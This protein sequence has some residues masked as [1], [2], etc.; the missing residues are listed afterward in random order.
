MKVLERVLGFLNK[1]V[2]CLWNWEKNFCETSRYRGVF[3]ENKFFLFCLEGGL[4][5][6]VEQGLFLVL[7]LFL[8]VVEALFMW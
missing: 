4:V 8:C 6:L 5:R 7:F 3:F 1:D 2:L